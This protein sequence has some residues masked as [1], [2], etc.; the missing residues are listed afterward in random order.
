[1][2]NF[3]NANEGRGRIRAEPE[4]WV[5][6]RARTLKSDPHPDGLTFKILLKKIASK[7]L[8]NL[9]KNPIFFAHYARDL[10]QF[11]HFVAGYDGKLCR[12][13][14]LSL[15]ALVTLLHLHVVDPNFRTRTL[16]FDPNPEF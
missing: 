10:I 16:D 9:Y 5:L 14:I 2:A 3:V 13:K 4:P 11:L 15:A 7:I 6:S 8:P 1:M 12:I